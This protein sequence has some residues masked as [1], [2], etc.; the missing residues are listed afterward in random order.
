MD[1]E[2][3]IEYIKKNI[4]I[5]LSQ[6]GIGIRAKYA[7]CNRIQGTFPYDAM[8]H[9]NQLKKI[10]NGDTLFINCLVPNIHYV[11]DYLHNYLTAKQKENQSFKIKFLLMGE[12]TIPMWIIEKLY[13]FA[14][15]MYLDN[16]TYEDPKIGYM[17]IGLRDG[18]E[19][20]PD[21]QHFTGQFIINEIQQK[22]EKEFLCLLCFSYTHPE[23]KKCEN[24]LGNKDFILNLN[25]SNEYNGQP[26]IHCGKVP[27]TINYEYTHK[28]YYA[29]SPSGVGE[30][31]HRFYEAIALKTIPIVK[32]TNTTF[33]YIYED[34]PCLVVD[35]WEDVTKELL[36]RKQKNL[37]KT[38]E[39]FHHK[40]PHFLTNPEYEFFSPR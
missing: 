1:Y 21:H 14:E 40:Y 9:E 26:S 20:H 23:R 32:R 24:V 27:V 37:T 31:T 2:K 39:E 34:F 28:S 6:M 7:I 33:D 30:A 5:Y 8:I 25:K 18:E 22:R 19:I 3:R 35:E 10:Q 4:I 17:P 13:P 12:P 36:E 38:M 11:V 16:N 29:L 15:K